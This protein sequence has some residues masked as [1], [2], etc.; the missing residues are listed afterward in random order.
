MPFGPGEA[1]GRARSYPPHR[2]P[3]QGPPRRTSWLVAESPGFTGLGAPSLPG[4]PFL[5]LPGQCINSQP[6]LWALTHCVAPLMRGRPGRRR[7]RARATGL[8][9]VGSPRAGAVAALPRGWGV[10]QCATT[11]LAGAVPRP[12]VRGARGRF[13]GFG[14]VPGV[15]SPLFPPSRPPCPALCVASRPFR[16]SLTLARR[17]A[18][19]RGLCV[20]RARSGCPSGISRVPC[21]RV[22]AR[23]PAASA[24]PP[25]FP[26]QVWRAH[27]ARSR[28]W[29]LVAP[30]HA[31]PA[32]PRVLPWS[33]APSGVLGGGRPGPVSPLPGLGWRA[34]RGVG[35]RVR[36]VPAPGGGLGGGG[37]RPVRRAPRLCGRGGLWRGGS[38]CL[39]PSLCL[40]WAGNKAG[41]TGV[42]LVMEGVAPIPLQFVLACG[43]LARPVWRPGALV[44]VRLFPAVPA[45]AGGWGGGAGLAPAP[46]TGAAVPPGGGGTI[47]SASGGWGPAP[48]RFAVRRG[49]GGGGG[50]GG[51][52][53]AAAPLLSLRRAARGSLPC[54]PS[55]R[56]RIPPRRARSVGVAGPPRAPGA[57]CLA[58][59][60]G[61]GRP[62]NRSPGAPSD[63]SHPSALPEWAT[64][65]LFPV[66]LWPWGARPPYCSGSSPRAAPGR[67]PR[68]APAR[69]C[70]L[71]RRPRPPREQAAGDAGARGVRVQLR[72]SPRVAVSFGGG[73]A[74]PRP[75]GGGG[76][77]LLRPAGRGGSGGGGRGGRSAAPHPRAPSGVGLPS[78]VSGAPPRGILVLSGFP[79]GR[80]RQ[81]RSGRPPVG[82]CGGGG[83][84]RGGVI[85]SPWFAP[86]PSP[87]LS[88]SGPLLLP[89]PGR[90]RSVVGR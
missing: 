71:A 1:P 47:P 18:I 29:A 65:R 88:L 23:A 30:F 86:L 17:Y 60:G 38:L 59:E 19:P 24:S 54:P 41:V 5:P 77:A 78:F 61:E 12:F 8:S 14:P 31:V 83:G 50:V 48:P 55:R 25:P 49:G 32:P 40:P 9:P 27:P 85:P 26:W 44:R 39:V 45:G 2:V 6:W 22:C 63:P 80:G 66:M 72:P 11:A 67:G 89:H 7:C 64:L 62:V 42:V 4:F 16:V 37:G 69:C 57:A 15:L 87:G 82:Q 58:G 33:L 73:G 84:G 68:A 79:G 90:R 46:L 70:G 13:G 52:G 75:Q 3:V 21:V 81:A 76:S 53:R 56:R 35:L 10:A 34:P 28:H 43:L 20:P 74:S 51:R 36:G